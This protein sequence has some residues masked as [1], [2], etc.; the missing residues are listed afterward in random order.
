MRYLLPL[1]VLAPLLELELALAAGAGLAAAVD[2]EPL[3]DDLASAAGSDFVMLDDAGV[4]F[5]R[6]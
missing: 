3:L 2:P 6:A 5:L 4:E 1:L